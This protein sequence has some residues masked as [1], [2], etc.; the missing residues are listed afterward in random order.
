[1][2]EEALVQ[3][4]TDEHG[5]PRT[6]EMVS[7]DDAIQLMNQLH[8]AA[9]L[10]NGFTPP[11]DWMQLTEVST[12]ELADV[13][14]GHLSKKGWQRVLDATRYHNHEIAGSPWDLSRTSDFLA[15][16]ELALT[17]REVT[18]HC[19]KRN[20]ALKEIFAN[21]P[22]ERI[23]SLTRNLQRQMQVL[24]HAL[25]KPTGVGD[26]LLSPKALWTRLSAHAM[27]ARAEAQIESTLSEAALYAARMVGTDAERDLAL[28]RVDRLRTHLRQQLETYC[29]EEGI[30][31]P[32]PFSREEAYCLHLLTAY[33]VSLAEA[34]QAIAR[35][36]AALANRQIALEGDR[37]EAHMNSQLLPELLDTLCEINPMREGFLR[38]RVR[39]KSALMVS[40]VVAVVAGGVWALIESVSEVLIAGMTR[41]APVVAPPLMVSI[42][43]LVA[44]TITQ[45]PPLTWESLLDFTARALWNGI[46]TLGGTL[47]VYGCWQYFNSRQPKGDT[48]AQEAATQAGR[49]NDVEST[50]GVA[51]RGRSMGSLPIDQLHTGQPADHPERK[52]G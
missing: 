31:L 15:A 35:R 19:K 37:A 32:K 50:E 8:E 45:G 11:T 36:G 9:M 20:V 48:S 51:Q 22:A 7:R 42:A 44:Q 12:G 2:V 28:A 38:E 17:R 43:T 10:R 52:Q 18:V 41:F 5:D 23:S 25:M 46:L 27:R 16:A 40:G 30:P 34:E 13:V 39:H 47:T 6:L 26:W 4:H 49:G 14:Q 33:F 3:N 1:M 24:I 21:L 29:E